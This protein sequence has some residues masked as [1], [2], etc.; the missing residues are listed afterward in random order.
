[1]V[2]LVAQAYETWWSLSLV[3]EEN[4]EEGDPSPEAYRAGAAAAREKAIGYYS[5]IV[6]ANPDGVEANCSRKPLALLKANEDTR[7]RRFYCYCD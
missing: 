1:V 5:E 2:F 6:A 3:P 7:Q 4:R